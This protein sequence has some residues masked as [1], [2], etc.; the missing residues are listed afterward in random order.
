MPLRP[1]LLPRAAP[2]DSGVSS[3]AVGALLDRLE[4]RAVECHSIMVVCRGHVV[5]EGW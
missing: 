1:E 4:A 2:A 5:A 3:R